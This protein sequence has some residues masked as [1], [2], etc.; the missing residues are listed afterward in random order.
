MLLLFL[1]FVVDN[2]L[3]WQLQSLSR[4]HRNSSPLFC[5]ANNDHSF[6]EQQQQ[7][8]QQQLSRRRLF[9]SAAGTT[10][11]WA[12][13][14]LNPDTTV[15]AAM[16]TSV[17]DPRAI[18]TIRLESSTDRLGLQLVNTS[19][20]GKPIAVIQ[21]V[22]SNKNNR[23]LEPGMI[24]LNF[25][26]AKDVVD[27]IQSGPFPLELKFYN[28][29]A[30]GDAFN[31]LGSTMVTPQDALD[32]AKQTEDSAA[33]MTTTA[34]TSSSSSMVNAAPEEYSITSLNNSNDGTTTGTNGRLCA[35]QSRRGDVLEIDY[36]AAALVG[37]RRIV[38]D[39]SA[40]R[41]TGLPYQMVLGSGDMLPG[42]D[43]GLYD[44]CPGQE[45]LLKI[46]P[47]LAYGGR[48]NKLFKI[49]PESPLEWQVKLVTI[50]GTIREDNND[51]TREDREGRALY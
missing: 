16:T 31:D 28:L 26:S 2:A 15:A 39:A 11:G 42:V 19:L 35:M 45:R 25:E 24:L 17:L 34:T 27:R 18:V 46:P 10:T 47:R 30:G 20:R 37:G 49:P 22:M 13:L 36:E 33:P 51:Q 7:Q 41:G 32:L 21:Q 38:Y 43:L 6:Q 9:Q 48:G 8:Q 5:D 29:A 40:F 12:L 44:M 4:N 1:V 3:A 23:K 50:D 14:L